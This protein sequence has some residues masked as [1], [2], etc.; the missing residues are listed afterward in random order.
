M[1]TA[2]N[3]FQPAVKE[4]LKAR[5]ALDGP[6]GSGKTWT[7]LSMATEIAQGAKV[8][9]ID[10]ERGKAKL[11]A[12]RF[13]FDHLSFE[14]PYE[15]ERL[16]GLLQAAE[17]NGYAV[18]IIDSLSHF[19]MGEGGVLD[20]V[21]AAAQKAHGN[22]FAGWK[23]GT[24]LQRHM[25]DVILGL[26]LHVITCMRSKMEYV[27]EQDERGRQVP[28]KIG[29]APVQREGLEYEFDL[30]G[31]LDLEHRI[32]ITKTRCDVLPGMIQPH[33]EAELARQFVDWLNDGEAPPPRASDEDV[34][35]FL[36]DVKGRDDSVRQAMNAWWSAQG[37]TSDRVLV[38][39][40]DAAR[41]HLADLLI[42]SAGGATS[43]E[44]D[45]S[46]GEVGDTGDDRTNSDANAVAASPD[47]GGGEG[48]SN[49]DGIASSPPT[50]VS[51]V[52]GSR[53]PAAGNGA[54]E[55][56]DS[57][58]GSSRPSEPDPETDACTRCGS[59]RSARTV[60]RGEVVCEIIPAC[61]QRQE[62]AAKATSAA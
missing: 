43:G 32:I 46:P 50:A 48:S 18:V 1:T 3:P 27:L 8:A 2:A 61:R 10:T 62:T 53:D 13:T 35:G 25:V 49:G 23:H 17:A 51:D 12:H 57:A 11:Y 33:R 42:E 19:W 55:G 26:D 22:S 4:Q 7:A 6:T 58:P 45:E 47:A 28:R 5:I 16:I 41:A 20:E 39:E 24:P 21:D 56:P 59:V 30:I 44:P 52:Q 15:V 31:D 37:F 9:V 40:L 34:A 29:M 38:T 60:V 14:P 54:S 36:D